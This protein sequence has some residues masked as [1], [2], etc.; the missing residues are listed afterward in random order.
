MRACPKR[1]QRKKINSSFRPQVCSRQFGTKRPRQGKTPYQASAF[2]IRVGAMKHTYSSYFVQLSTQDSDWEADAK[3]I[4]DG[5][6]KF[7]ISDASPGDVGRLEAL[8]LR[9]DYLYA[10]NDLTSLVHV[11]PK[12]TITRPLQP[13]LESSRRECPVPSLAGCSN[14]SP[15]F[16]AKT[17]Q[18]FAGACAAG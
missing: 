1:V 6:L 18:R 13:L 10:F 5:G 3:I 4:M 15:R 14:I 17:I 8:A 16:P 11:E 2:F 12:N 7:I 9:Y